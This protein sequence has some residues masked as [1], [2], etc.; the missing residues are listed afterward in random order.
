VRQD[1]KGR[2]RGTFFIPQTIYLAGVLLPN[3]CCGGTAATL[4]RASAC[5]IGLF[6]HDRLHLH[7]VQ[8]SCAFGC[9]ARDEPGVEPGGEQLFAE[10]GLAPDELVAR[11]QARLEPYCSRI[12]GGCHLARNVPR[13]LDEAGF[14]ADMATGYVAWPRSLS[15]NF[16]GAATAAA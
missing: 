5:R 7:A 16:V 9:A 13:L 10:H 8:Y 4:G 6:R 1:G 15:F 12:A 2:R 14:S 11:W 3:F